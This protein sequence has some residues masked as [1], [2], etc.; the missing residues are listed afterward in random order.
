MHQAVLQPPQCQGGNGRGVAR[1]DLSGEP[2]KPYCLGE[3]F[4]MEREA[5]LTPEV[6]SWSEGTLWARQRTAPNCAMP[7][8][9]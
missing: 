6:G 3:G 4:Q 5:E 1:M 7:R 9:D 2:C 8:S